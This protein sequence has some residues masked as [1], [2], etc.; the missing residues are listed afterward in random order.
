V[1]RAD[2]GEALGVTPLVRALPRTAGTL[3]L[4]I[5]LAGYVPLERSV[6]LEKDYELDL[7]LAKARGSS[8]QQRPR[9]V[10]AKRVASERP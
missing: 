4:R 9:R 8:G 1:V 3:D 7:P 10:T 6:P 2:T 5:R